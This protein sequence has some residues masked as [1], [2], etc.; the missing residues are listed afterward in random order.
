MHPTAERAL[1]EFRSAAKGL[2][3][4][5][6]STPLERLGWAPPPTSRSPLGV[7]AHAAIAVE[8]MLGN[9]TGETF[10]VSTSAEADAL[11][12]KREAAYESKEQVLGLLTAN[13]AAYEEWLATVDDG[14]LATHV[15]LPFGMGEVPM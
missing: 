13:A 5:L 2:E 12:L 6:D 14:I 9:L 4:A 7:A 11:F 15:K 8:S 10:A 3:R 1:L